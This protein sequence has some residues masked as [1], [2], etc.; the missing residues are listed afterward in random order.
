[1]PPDCR[2]SLRP[3]LILNSSLGTSPFFL[4]CKIGPI[5]PLQN[6]D[7]LHQTEVLV[8]ILESEQ[9]LSLIPIY[10]FIFSL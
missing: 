3:T 6:I 7:T 2:P 8:L 5:S 9:Q 1:M 10:L 4:F